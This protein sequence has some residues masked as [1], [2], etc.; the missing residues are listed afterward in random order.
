MRIVKTTSLLLSLLL[1]QAGYSETMFCETSTIE[2]DHGYSFSYDP[3]AEV[4]TSKGGYSVCIE[5]LNCVDHKG[6]GEITQGRTGKFPLVK[7]HVSGDLFSLEKFIGPNKRCI[8]GEMMQTYQGGEVMFAEIQCIDSR[9]EWEEC[10]PSSDMKL[11][12]NRFPM[13]SK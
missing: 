12:Q 10:W 7:F 5:G 8:A 4:F 2:D 13:R 1:S 11:N 6:G 3:K 9:Y